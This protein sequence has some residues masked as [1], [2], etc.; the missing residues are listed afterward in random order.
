MIWPGY[1]P[2]PGIRSGG[3]FDRSG[4]IY[5][6]AGDAMQ[7]VGHCLVPD[8]DDHIHQVFLGPTSGQEGIHQSRVGVAALDGDVLYQAS[9]RVE[10]AIETG[11]AATYLQHL[12]IS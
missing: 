5:R 6:D 8:D 2:Y 3:E 7:I 1:M 9:Q 12:R 11:C 10:L 4:E